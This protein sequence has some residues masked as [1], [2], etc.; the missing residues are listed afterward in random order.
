MEFSFFRLAGALWAAPAAKAVWVLAVREVK[1]MSLQE[2]AAMLSAL[3][4]PGHQSFPQAWAEQA[5]VAGRLKAL[6]EE[7][8]VTGAAVMEWTGARLPGVEAVSLQ[9]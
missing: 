2:T 3:T 7:T 1:A 5:T 9:S 4:E 8:G 6:W